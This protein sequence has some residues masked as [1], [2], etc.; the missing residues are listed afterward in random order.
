MLEVYSCHIPLLQNPKIPEILSGARTT[1]NFRDRMESFRS[2]KVDDDEQNH[3]PCDVNNGEREVL[4]GQLRET[5]VSVGYS[6]LY[7]YASG[8]DIVII[9]VCSLCAV[10]AG[11]V[12]PLM[13]VWNSLPALMLL[14]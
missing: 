3:A 8:R 14:H 2:E 12:L 5:T 1:D 7:R 6:S 9:A 10:V 13:T 4:E 11:A